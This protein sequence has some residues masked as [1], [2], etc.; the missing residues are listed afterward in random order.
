MPVFHRLVTRM[1]KGKVRLDVFDAATNVKK[2]GVFPFG[3]FRG[4]IT[5]MQADFNGD[6]F[7]DLLVLG[8]QGGRL[9]QRLYSGVDLSVLA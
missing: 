3:R 8:V 2:G 1:V 5:I 7:A 4:K 6:G 9:R